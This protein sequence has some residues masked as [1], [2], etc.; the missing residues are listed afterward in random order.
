[1]DD[2]SNYNPGWKYSYW[3]LKGVPLRL[4]MGPK[5]MAQKQIRIV[6]RDTGDKEDTPL[7][8]L[9]QK[10]GAVGVARVAQGRGRWGRVCS[11][12]PIVWCR[13]TLEGGKGEGN[14][15][16]NRFHG[17]R[18]IVVG[19]QCYSRRSTSTS[20]EHPSPFS[21]DT[22]S[23][24]LFHTQVA[25]LLVTMQHDL[26]IKARAERDANVTTALTWPDFMA[27]IADGKVSQPACAAGFCCTLRSAAVC[28]RLLN[29]LP[30]QIAAGCA[31]AS[32]TLSG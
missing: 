11:R 8:I 26:L 18:A 20:S 15:R 31:R 14:E 16:K 17:L 29:G 9:T 13:S 27:K 7:S 32:G 21:L 2:R 22:C 12:V 30:F 6:R 3:E 1:V 19:R 5:D 23:L 4:E 24:S 28:H 10:V 25:L